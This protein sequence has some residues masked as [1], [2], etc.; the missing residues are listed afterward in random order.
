MSDELL[1]P[2]REI[3]HLCDMLLSDTDASLDEKQRKHLRGI[4]DM[5]GDQYI[6]GN[7]PSGLLSGF[8]W[9]AT[10]TDTEGN[11]H[12]SAQELGYFVR[13]PSPQFAQ[14]YMSYSD[15]TK[16]QGISTRSSVHMSSGYNTALIRFRSN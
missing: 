16:K 8:D 11:G 5:A 7:Y 3:I 15:L 4:L 2:T 12:R 1:E 9:Y 14:K 13:T 10:Q 6:D